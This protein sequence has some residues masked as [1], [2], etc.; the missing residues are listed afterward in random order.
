MNIDRWKDIIANIKDNFQVEDSGKE[1]IEDDGG[2]DVE[3]IVFTSSQGK[4][5]LEFVCKPVILDKKTTFSKRIGSETTVEYVYS[6]TE[7]N[8]HLIAYRW[9]DSEDDW[10]EIDAKNFS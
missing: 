7:K 8:Q 10:Q 4:F 6:D 1:H 3:Y 5:R 2:V 9:S